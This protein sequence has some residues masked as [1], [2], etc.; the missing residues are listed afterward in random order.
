[1]QTEGSTFSFKGTYKFEAGHGTN[2]CPYYSKRQTCS[3]FRQV[4]GNLQ[5]S[6][7]LRHSQCARPLIRGGV[8]RIQLFVTNFDKS[9]SIDCP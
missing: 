8:L 9:V 3:S 4:Q 5:P 2:H 7:C 1:M 6:N